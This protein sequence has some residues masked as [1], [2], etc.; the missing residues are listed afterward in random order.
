M[1]DCHSPSVVLHD[2]ADVLAIGVKY[3][4]AWLCVVPENRIAIAVLE[5]IQKMGMNTKRK[6]CMKRFPARW[7]FVENR[8][9][10]DISFTASAVRGVRAACAREV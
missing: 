7:V 1:N 8:N 9:P 6:A 10:A 3:Q 5:G 2:D 4:V